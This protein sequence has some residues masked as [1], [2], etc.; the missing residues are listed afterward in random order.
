[1]HASEALLLRKSASSSFLKPDGRTTIVS[2]ISLPSALEF[3]RYVPFH[4]GYSISATI[5]RDANIEQIQEQL[6]QELSDS[7]SIQ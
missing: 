6:L 1:M 7:K 4:L 3:K 5:S 2:F